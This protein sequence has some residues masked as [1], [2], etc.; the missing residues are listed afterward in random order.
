MKINFLGD[1]ITQGA[2]ASV[3]EKNY[4]S[5]VGQILGCEVAN[6]GIGGTRI[7]KRSGEDPYPEYFILRAKKMKD[8][9]LVFVFGGTNDYGHGD[10]P[11]GSYEDRTSDTFCGAFCELTDYLISRYGKEKL[12]YILPLPRYDQDNPYGDG[13][14]MKTVPG[15]TLTEYIKA[16]RDLLFKYGIDTLDLSDVFEVPKVNTPTEL[17]QDGLHPNDKGHRLIAERVSE[18]VRK[19]FAL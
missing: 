2:C 7:A 17:M 11:F 4:V 3:E 15:P 6:F 9:D 12:C 10:A 5:L 13:S 16:E 19:K 8:A 18:Y 14:G 1:S